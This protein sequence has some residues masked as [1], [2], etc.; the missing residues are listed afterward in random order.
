MLMDTPILIPTEDNK[1]P[2]F[3]LLQLSDPLFPIGGFTQSYGLETYVQKGIVHDAET[4]EK[5]LKSYLLNSFLYNDLLAVKLSWEYT[6]EGDLDKILE[7]EEVF[8]ASKAPSELRTASQKLGK[9]F[10][11][12]LEFGLSENKM[13]NELYE[14]VKEGNIEVS[15]P[16]MYGFCTKLLQVG[17]K[18]ALAA[19]T[20]GTASSIINNCAKLVP[21]SQTDGQ[22]IL[23]NAHDIYRKLLEK[24]EEL[25]E[26]HLGICCFG[27]DLRAMQ[28]ERLYTRL[29][30]S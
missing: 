5:Y 22:K 16:V 2:F 23:F 1:I 4:S 3:Y 18:E 19:V 9:R 10:L 13:F 12:I 8:S 26:E 20:Y 29:Y 17:K 21:I 14:R 15:Y 25:K 11:K 28:H 30:I 24:V 6:Q 7:L 27:F